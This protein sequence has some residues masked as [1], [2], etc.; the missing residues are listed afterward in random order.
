[1]SGVFLCAPRSPATVPKQSHQ[2]HP[3]RLHKE[4]LLTRHLRCCLL[5]LHPQVPKALQAALPFKTKPKLEPARSRKTLEQK[6]AVVLE[7]S[8]RKAVTLLQQ[9]NA[10]RNEKAKKRAEQ[11]VGARANVGYKLRIS[12]WEMQSSGVE[13]RKR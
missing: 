9:L 13:R 4:L 7:P 8:E 2:P 10:I 11:N 5:S 1:M 3:A 12:R 6:R